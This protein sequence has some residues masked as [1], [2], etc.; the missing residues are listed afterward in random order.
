MIRIIGEGGYGRVYLAHDPDLERDVAI[1]VPLH[2][3]Y[4]PSLNVEAYLNE[5]RILARLSHPN[6]VPVYDVGRTKDGTCFVVS[7]YMDGGDLAARISRGRLT[8]LDS[9]S[10]VAL[11]VRRA[12]LHSH[13]RYVSP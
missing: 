10:L 5:A 7:K 1:K 9:A 4:S 11:L 8:Y 12:S 3:E 13:A 6:I 2:G